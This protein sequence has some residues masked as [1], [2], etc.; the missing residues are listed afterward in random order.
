MS[1]PE[2]ADGL[3]SLFKR[4]S[5]FVL[6]GL[7]GRTGSGCSQTAKLL[8]M[9]FDELK[10]PENK[11]VGASAEDRK[12]RIV[13]DYAQRNWKPFF[14]IT[15]SNVIL[16]FLLDCEETALRQFFGQANLISKSNR[17]DE[18]IE[19]WKPANS[20]WLAVRE[21]L[22]KPS[23]DVASKEA[24]LVSWRGPIQTFFNTV[25]IGLEAESTKILQQVGDNLRKSGNPFS[26]A[27]IPDQFYELPHRTAQLVD[28]IRHIQGAKDQPA[29]IV[30]DALRNP[31]ELLYFRERFAAFYVFAVSSPDE[32]RKTR[33]SVRRN[34][35]AKVIDELDA[36]EYPERGGPLSGYE[37]FTSQNI[38]SCLEKA[39]VY[40][41]N[42]G[43]VPP[44][45]EVDTSL[46][47][48]QL[49]KYFSLI[50][51][52]G[53][54]TPTQGERCMQIAFAARAN[55]G[56]ISRQ[57]GAAIT[58]EHYSVKA[59]GWNDVPSGQVPC[60]LR[61]A[62]DLL[63]GVDKEAFSDYENRDTKFKNQVTSSYKRYSLIDASGRSS[64]YC[65]K[66]E[67]NT[68]V[69]EK[70]Q[71]H[72]RSLHAEENAFL[73]I[74]KQGGQG[75][76]GGKLYTTA[77]PCELCAKKAFQLGIKH[78]YYIDPYPGISLTHILAAGHSDVRPSVELYQGAVGTAYH[79]LFDPILPF[80]DELRA[81]MEG[82]ENDLAVATPSASERLI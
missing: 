52:P 66:T 5:K 64:A 82:K 53:L 59:V 75:I 47:A 35:S 63:S 54:V 74:V 1:N 19:S 25:R 15:V 22:N 68:L 62:T 51:H 24:F 29:Y 39:D 33:L 80:K 48:L 76:A 13:K 17:L 55:S 4:R 38:Q 10:L 67:Y 79:R 46:L 2:V 70:N 81:L 69:K 45:Q 11:L 57:V 73:Q 9:N 34:Y 16:S 30:L 49:V 41:T 65:F 36:K 23:S 8:S 77:S 26:N 21:A 43:Y 71:V 14:S 56:C 44:T 37:A 28:L 78:I 58:D 27:H 72:T 31:F 61:R 50:L 12:H 18:F 32:D 3:N 20:A 40:L 7:T 6:I 42:S 60:Q